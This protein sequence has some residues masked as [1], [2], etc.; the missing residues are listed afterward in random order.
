MRCTRPS[1]PP[2]RTTT[3]CSPPRRSRSTCARGSKET[4]MLA[5]PFRT[6]KE[7]AADIRRKKIGCLEL[8]D[9]YLERVAKHNPSLN[10]IIAMDVD[11]ARKRA[12]AADRALARKQ[13]WGPLHGVPMTIKE[14][15]DVVGMP[16]TRGIPELKDNFPPRNAL[17]VD[18]LLDAGVV[19]FGKTNVPIHLAD[20]QSYNAIYGITN[21]PSDLSRSPGGSSGGSAAALAAGLTGLEAGSDIG[22]SIRNP[23]HYC[24]VYGHKPTWGVVP[25]RGQA[26]PGKITPTDISVIGPLARSAADLDIAL[27][28]MAGP[29]EID[30]EG[31]QLRLP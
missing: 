25:P 27:S 31:W 9:L 5:T 11:G 24:G 8:L 30:G 15:Y 29:D 19:L 1:P 20:Y 17:A 23:A 3:D 7:L 26:T 21:N 28:I 4:L 12:R 22:S 18:R 2:I 13:M 6:A 14:S 10:A 16:T